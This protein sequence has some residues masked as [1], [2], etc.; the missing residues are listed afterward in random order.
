MTQQISDK[1]K[2]VLKNVVEKWWFSYALI[3]SSFN[4]T[5]PEASLIRGEMQHYDLK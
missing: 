1:M 5:K 3:R 4:L 2:K